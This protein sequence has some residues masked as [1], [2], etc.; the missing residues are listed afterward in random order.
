MP[1]REGQLYNLLFGEPLC[2]R[3]GRSGI[4]PIDRTT[5]GLDP[6]LKSV[7]RVMRRDLSDNKTTVEPIEQAELEWN[8]VVSLPHN[9]YAQVASKRAALL[10]A[11][12]R[13]PCI[14]V[15]YSF[16]EPQL[17]MDLESRI[18]PL[19]MPAFV[20]CQAQSPDSLVLLT[21]V[22]LTMW[23][24]RDV[25]AVAYKRASLPPESPRSAT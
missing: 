22:L 15:Y 3:V 9:T 16:R 11:L 23:D 21:A 20:G 1:E 13:F 5:I 10:F 24:P 18:L 17:V 4:R 14:R 8:R 7:V 25:G 6:I 19:V 2:A 12:W